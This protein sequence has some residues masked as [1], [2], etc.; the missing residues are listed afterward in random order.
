MSDVREGASAAPEEACG[1]ADTAGLAA[2]LERLSAA[3][4][5]L[6]QDFERLAAAVTPLLTGQ[7]RE[8]ERRV[9]VLETRLR[10]RQERPL[11]FRMANLLADV[12]RLESAEDIKDHVEESMMDTLSSAGYQEYGLAG[13]RF[14][15]TLHEPLSGSMG[16]AAVVTHVHSR[17][18]ACYGDV[19]IKAKV[20]VE[21]GPAEWLG[22]EAG[23]V[24]PVGDEPIPADEAGR[25]GLPA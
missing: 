17:G 22:T 18:L 12:R 6:R 15:P 7:Y 4:D 16:R 11:I 10:N 13:D 8:T 2:T 20:D 9:R 21:P 23:P 14:D 3:Q 19:I 5:L 1:P 25:E 24:P